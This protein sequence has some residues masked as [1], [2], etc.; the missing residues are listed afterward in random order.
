MM[1]DYPGLEF[2]CIAQKNVV[3]VVGDFR[4]AF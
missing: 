1:Q 4:A 3:S 2:R